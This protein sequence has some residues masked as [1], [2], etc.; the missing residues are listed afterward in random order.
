MRDYDNCINVSCCV[1]ECPPQPAP[2]IKPENFE[3]DPIATSQLSAPSRRKRRRPPQHIYK[4]YDDWVIV[5][6]VQK[7]RLRAYKVCAPLRDERKNL[8]RRRSTAKT[9]PVGTPNFSLPES[10]T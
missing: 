9:A 1:D 4:Q 8:S 2:A 6:G 10:P 5:S 3:L 7:Q